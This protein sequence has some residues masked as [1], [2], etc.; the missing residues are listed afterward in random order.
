MLDTADKIL[1]RIIHQEIE[2]VVDP[3]F[4]DNQYGFREERS[5]LDAITIVTG[6]R[7]KGG[8][9]KN[10]LVATLDIIN[11]FYSANR[12]CVM[13]VLEEKN[14]PKYLCRVMASYFTNRIL[15]YDT[16]KGPKITGGV[17]KDALEI[18]ETSRKAGPV[19]QL[20]ALKLDSVFREEAVSVIS[21][22]LPL[23]VLTQDRLFTNERV[24][25]NSKNGII[26]YVDGSYNEMLQRKEMAASERISTASS[27]MIYR[28]TRPAPGNQ[29]TRSTRF[30]LQRDELETILNQRIQPETLVEG[31]LSTKAAWNA[32]STFATEV[33]TDLRSIERR[34]ARDSN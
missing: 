15:K 34:R 9:K 22:I 31:M 3:F 25:R 12:D 5:T 14:I 29:K 6:T 13:R 32:T 18:Q 26:V 21:G 20:S 27:A 4:A 19:Y 23:R 16:E 24:L 30:N 8:T 10:Y 17:P 33:L 28:S 2:V 11:S 7:W 1:E